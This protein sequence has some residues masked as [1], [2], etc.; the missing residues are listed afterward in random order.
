MFQ[1]VAGFDAKIKQYAEGEQFI[2][3]V[4]SH[5]GTELLDRAWAD[6]ANVPSIDEIRT[7]KLWIER[8]GSGVAA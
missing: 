6:P 4:E 5:G 3:V 2:E 1:R 8:V 7:P